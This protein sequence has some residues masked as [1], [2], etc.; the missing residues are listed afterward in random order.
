MLELRPDRDT[1]TLD[2][3]EGIRWAT[4]QDSRLLTAFG[5]SIAIVHQRF[6]AGDRA[7]M[8]LESGQVLAYV[9]FH[10]VEHED[11]NLGVRFRL[12]PTEIWLFDAM[13][14]ADHR[15]RGLYP[16]LLRSAAADLWNDGFSR[17]L[18]AVEASNHNSMRAHRAVGA[19]NTG[20]LHATRILGMTFLY[21]GSHFRIRWTG[22]R[23]WVELSSHTFAARS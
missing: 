8:L 9:W 21:D 12:G 16:R 1:M 2:D 3:R 13:V 11:E 20:S 22:S 5:H 7:C 23:G 18:I 10:A 14:A 15:G 19:R 4:T 6:S 17:I